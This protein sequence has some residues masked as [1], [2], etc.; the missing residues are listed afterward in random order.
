MMNSKSGE[1]CLE[2]IIGIFT[3]IGIISSLIIAAGVFAAWHESKKPKEVKPEAIV[4]EEPEQEAKT[5]EPIPYD[6]ISKGQYLYY[7]TYS[8]DGLIQGSTNVIMEKPVA[9]WANIYGTNSLMS[10]LL[11][12]GN[13]RFTN[14]E[15]T[16]VNFQCIAMRKQNKSE[17]QKD[18]K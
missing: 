15:I 18:R 9:E 12:S 5:Q 11:S 6:R 7:I 17:S 4:F 2:A 16:I 1:G 10:R 3:A 13:Q 8:F 14:K